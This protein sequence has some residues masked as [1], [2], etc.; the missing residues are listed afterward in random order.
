MHTTNIFSKH[1]YSTN[2]S[3]YTH[4]YTFPTP[5][6]WVCRV[7]Y[8][9]CIMRLCRRKVA[10]FKLCE[11][12]MWPVTKVK[13]KLPWFLVWSCRIWYICTVTL[14][15]DDQHSSTSFL[16]RI[17]LNVKDPFLNSCAWMWHLQ[18]A[19]LFCRLCLTNAR[20]HTATRHAHVFSVTL[21]LNHIW[22]WLGIRWTKSTPYYFIK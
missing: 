20:K 5:T 6:D 19:M 7:S 11:P 4:I 14:H 13:C 3:H 8:L 17:V 12:I 2:S 16:A 18:K 21:A 10:I 15:L 22:L 1:C 9:I